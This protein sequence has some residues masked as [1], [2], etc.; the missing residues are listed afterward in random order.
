MTDI[1][2]EI[3]IVLKVSMN[4]KVKI[5]TMDKLLISIFRSAIFEILFSD[6]VK[7]KIVISE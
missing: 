7:K 1:L 2:D 4:K 6:N 5:N 3:K